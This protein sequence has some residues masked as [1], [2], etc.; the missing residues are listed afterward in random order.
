MRH[1]VKIRLLIVW[2]VKL[3]ILLWGSKVKPRTV[4]LMLSTFMLHNSFLMQC[5]CYA[6]NYPCQWQ[7]VG[8]ICKDNAF[9]QS[10]SILNKL[11]IIT[12]TCKGGIWDLFSLTRAKEQDNMTFKLKNKSNMAPSLWHYPG[13]VPALSIKSFFSSFSLSISRTQGLRNKPLQPRIPYQLFW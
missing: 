8:T 6:E 1:G 10:S 5:Y 3:S 2:F 4:V 11:L 13:A 12:I 7:I 9:C